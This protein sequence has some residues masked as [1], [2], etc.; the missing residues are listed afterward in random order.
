MNRVC[1]L[2][3]RTL[4][5]LTVVFCSTT[6]GQH[7]FAKDPAVSYQV[8]F[9]DVA[10]HYVH[11]E[12]TFPECPKGSNEFFL[13][14]WT[15]GSYLVREY[16][17]HVDQFQATGKDGEEIDVEKFSKNRWRI[18][19]PQAG[20]L[21]ISYRVYCNEMSVRTN[22]AD[23]EFAILN[24][25]ATFITQDSRVTSPHQVKLELPDAWKRSVTALPKAAETSAHK[26][27]AD[28]FDTLVDSPIL[29]GNP[30]LHPFEVGGKQ[31][32]L[33]NLGGDDLWDGD[34]AAAEVAKIVAEHQKMWQ[35]IPY[36]QYYFLNV[37]AESGGG[38]EHDNSTLLMTSRWSYR[39]PSRFKRWLGLVSHEFFHTWN[40][41]RLRPRA[42]TQY[43]YEDENYFQEL[44]VAEGVTSYF[45]NLACARAGVVS[46]TEYL[47]ALS[48]DIATLQ[49]TPGRK[50]QSL[51]E[52]SHDSW[53]KFYRPDENSRNTSISYYNKG[54]VVAFLLDAQVRKLTNNSKSL[55]EV[56]RLLYK[57]FANGKGYTNQEVM[58][59][60]SEVC[61]QDMSEWFSKHIDSTEELDYGPA[62][63]W[64][65][66]S[67]S[68]DD[69]PSKDPQ[70][71]TPTLQ[72]S[73]SS[74]DGKLTVTRVEEGGSGYRAG[75]NVDDE[76]I[77]INN[78]RI[79]SDIDT[80]LKQYEIGQ[81]VEV[82]TSRR[83]KLQRHWVVIASKP[84]KTWVL[85]R[86]SKPT[87]AQKESYRSWFGLP[88]TDSPKEE[89]KGQQ[90]TP[91]PVQAK[92][93]SGSQ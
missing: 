19:L 26:Y 52:S 15:P 10:K 83:G 67:F 25:A 8:G 81:E 61:G 41:R 39:S 23:Q 4:I 63:Q 65:G 82:L 55:D 60:T 59:V 79:T 44:W 33:A 84:K 1:R 51:S 93:V 50:A 89:S 78:Y 40:V 38:L 45:D 86:V 88:E 6:F 85:K 76:I 70:T 35:T 49:S 87:D 66:L 5:C 30:T 57:R 12:A 43:G 20:S 11:V 56:M 32:F 31:H 29:V 3:L 21:T 37:I 18:K 53:I 16:A 27:V 17:R 77:A 58:K 62:L 36:D 46:P 72:I 28:N 34:V 64:F 71:G 13:P 69:K 91:A 80:R 47:K 54:A 73:A 7:S 90:P 92:A 75:I 2:T 24:G 42:L 14:V 74:S 68:H 22:F 48:G 9:E